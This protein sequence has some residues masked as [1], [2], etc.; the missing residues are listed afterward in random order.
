MAAPYETE[1]ETPGEATVREDRASSSETTLVYGAPVAGFGVPGPASVFR[2]MRIAE[3]LPTKGAEAD[4][5]VVESCGELRVLKLYRHRLEPKLEI[6]NRITEIS[7][8]NSHYFVIFHETGFDEDTGRWYELQEYLPM[9]SLRDVPAAIKRD[10]N[11]IARMIPEMAAAIQCLHENG[12]IHCDIKPAN[13]LIRTLDPLDLVL[14]DFGISSLLASDMSQKMTSLK[15]TPMYWAPEAF[16]REIGRPCDWWGLGMTTLELLVGE[17]PFEG[18]SDSQIIHRLTLGNVEIPKSIDPVWTMLVKGL[19]TKDD[20]KRWGKSEIDRWSAGDSSVPL[21]YESSFSPVS[22]S[23]DAKKPFRFEGADYYELEELARALANSAAPWRNCLDYLRYIRTWFEGNLKFD[24]AMEIGKMAGREDPELALFKFVN[25]NARIPFSIKSVPATAA[26]IAGYL[27]KTNF[28]DSQY[29]RKA[30]F[31]GVSDGEMSII[32]M[33]KDGRLLAYYDEYA[34]CSEEDPNFR[35]LLKFMRNMTPDAQV[36]YFDI[37]LNPEDFVWPRDMTNADTR[38][39]L[40]TLEAIGR[41]PLRRERFERI[42]NDYVMPDKLI[43]LLDDAE[44]YREGAS[45][46]ES[47]AERELLFPRT[48]AEDAA[49]CAA[50]SLGEYEQSA[51]IHCLGHTSATLEQLD[52]ISRA[53]LRL[54]GAEDVYAAPVTRASVDR[55]NWLKDH[56]VSSLDKTF[57][58]KAGELLS[59]R[60]NTERGR[61]KRCAYYGA[62]IGAICVMA[63]L[64]GGESGDRLLRTALGLALAANA[65]FYFAVVRRD[66]ALR[67]ELPDL[68]L[69]WGYLGVVLLI[70]FLTFNSIIADH[71]LI[72]TFLI[73]ALPVTAFLFAAESRGLAKNAAAILELCASYNLKYNYV[74]TNRD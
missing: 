62:F 11:F 22:A 40:K 60:E 10:P 59:E 30:T 73:G 67:T 8:Q 66:E 63:H 39:V 31:G 42:Q 74:A 24:E 16:S 46:I 4:I 17:H 21:Y 68:N 29:L 41:R 53:L 47:W 38:G 72:F 45:L 28:G 51:R 7:R 19:L 50:M 9:G 25:K 57:I 23:F 54:P 32:E 33:L 56:K 27:R 13:I 36:E 2:G 61:W 58:M 44:S 64:F 65:I 71:P 1:F 55:M 20:T 34:L 70:A 26:D 43:K 49:A 52:M 37:V 5:Y 3:H 48:S 14:T 6:L 18:L 35:S 15:G 12:M 69:L